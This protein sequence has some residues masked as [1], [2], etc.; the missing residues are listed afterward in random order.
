MFF[1]NDFVISDKT[2]SCENGAHKMGIS[3]YKNNHF[4]A[5]PPNKVGKNRLSK[6]SAIR[7]KAA[8]NDKCLIMRL[9]WCFT[10][11]ANDFMCQE[12]KERSIIILIQLLFLQVPSS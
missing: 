11:F 9:V 10:I 4:F 12:V 7:K 8:N 2:F 6:E 3:G 5:N 1:A